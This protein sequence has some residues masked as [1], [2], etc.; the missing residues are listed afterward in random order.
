[1]HRTGIGADRLFISATHTH[2]GFGHFLAERQYNLSSSSIEG[3]DPALV[4]FLVTRISGSIID[5]FRQRRPAR[6]AWGMAP[7]RGHTRNRS[8]EAYC[9]N[10][11]SGQPA[12]DSA[13]R[14]PNQAPEEVRR[15]AIDTT[16]A[17][18]RVDL[19]DLASGSFVPA[20]AYSVFAIHG[21][22]NNIYNELLD[23]DIHGLA[24]R[25][26]ERAI[27]ESNGTPRQFPSR[28][29]H[30]L[31]NGTEGDVSPGWPRGSRCRPPAF[32]PQN[33][34]LG[35][36]A[37]DQSWRWRDPPAPTVGRCLQIA[38]KYVKQ[39]GD[40]LARTA[41]SL[42]R[43]LGSLVQDPASQHLHLARAFETLRLPGREGL[44][45]APATG[46]ATLA[47]AEDGE[48][49]LRGWSR[50]GILKSDMVE[51][52]RAAL[53][54]PNGC[55][56]KKRVAFG[57]GQQLILGEHGLPEVAQLAVVRVGSML[58]GVVPAEVTTTAG[59]LMKRAI[60]DGAGLNDRA[61]DSVMVV[62]LANGFLQ[63]ITTPKEYD[64][65][66]YEGGS[67]LYGPQSAPVLSHHLGALA[68]S[69]APAST[70]MDDVSPILANT[71]APREEN[72][73]ND[74]GPAPDSVTRRIV[75]TSCHGDTVVARWIDLYPGRLIPA[76][77]LLLTIHSGSPPAGNPVAWDD[78]PNMEI[79]E[80]GPARRG[81]QW[82][83]RWVPPDPLSAYSMKLLPHF[84]LP[85]LANDL[86]TCG[87]RK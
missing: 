22:G 56:G 47:G 8:F 12:V 76:N 63:Y 59:R 19:K 71:G 27:D 79:W 17:M 43:S 5:A 15:S 1:L 3:Y 24:E 25:G 39:V 44:C 41:D 60:S 57:A 23:A 85:Q 53:K 74:A 48:T 32:L 45:S 10:G 64:V 40:S 55:Q 34:L 11:S 16:W 42:F 81:Y 21:T 73:A 67:T 75:R 49:R 50:V 13:C 46:T 65:Q 84:G 61:A 54:Q 72:P 38:R 83:M 87:R 29:V 35:P 14:R 33:L 6:A 26:L 78:D 9:R 52:G 4:D 7:V 70:P 69:L 80:I 36:R 28:A 77:G 2:A 20:G 37:A 68:A 31:A 18:L 66:D 86:P 30:I 82:E 51:G 62:G 58:L